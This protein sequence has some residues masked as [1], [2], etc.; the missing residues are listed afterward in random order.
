MDSSAERKPVALYSLVLIKNIE[1]KVLLLRRINTRY[2]EGLFALPG[3]KVESGE[4]FAQAAARE[5]G[6]ELDICIEPQHLAFANLM[7][8]Y[9][10]DDQLL[11]ATFWVSAWNGALINKEPHRHQDLSWWSLDALPHDLLA[12]HKVILEA[13]SRGEGYAEHNWPKGA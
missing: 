7:Q 4:T 6:E 2:G 3:G 8:R 10:E 1:G 12:G 11:V 13:I 9:A 5:A